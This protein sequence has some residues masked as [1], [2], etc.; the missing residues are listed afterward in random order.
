MSSV[1]WPVIQLSGLRSETPIKT[2][3]TKD[4]VSFPWLVTIH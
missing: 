2:L 1:M 4:Q 3:D